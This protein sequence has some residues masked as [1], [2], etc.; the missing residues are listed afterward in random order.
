[1]EEHIRN[2][3][4]RAFDRFDNNL[5]LLCELSAPDIR[6]VKRWLFSILPEAALKTQGERP[7]L[8]QRLA[9][10]EMVGDAT[11]AAQK[12]FGWTK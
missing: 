5:D 10:R 12:I 1:V 11:Q 3:M 6:H 7:L 2:H 4:P 8:T 9:M